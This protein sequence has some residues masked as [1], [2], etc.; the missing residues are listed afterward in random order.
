MQFQEQ[1]ISNDIL[2]VFSAL[3]IA[4]RIAV[5]DRV[6]AHQRRGSSKTLSVTREKSWYC[7]YNVLIALRER[8][9]AKNI[10]GELE[11][12]FVNYALHVSLWNLNTLKEPTQQVLKEKLDEE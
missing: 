11:K 8:L 12:D 3:V 10:F 2:F 5:V 6:L 9:Q 7:F 1:R 4:K